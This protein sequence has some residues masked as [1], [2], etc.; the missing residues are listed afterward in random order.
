MS[1]HIIENL[2]SKAGNMA[3]NSFLYDWSL[4]EDTPDRLAV[5]LV[6]PRSGSRQNARDLLNAIGVE[7]HKDPLWYSQWWNPEEA[8]DIWLSHMHGFSWLRDLR[9]LGSALAREQGRLMIENWID[10]NGSWNADTWRADL[11]GRRLAMWICHYEFFCANTDEEFEDKLLFSI[12]KQAKHLSNTINKLS[13]IELL[14]AIKGLLYCAI[15]LDNHDEWLE[16]ALNA[17]EKETN[18]QI[19]PDGGHASRSPAILLDALEIMVDTRTALKTGGYPVPEFLTDVIN[20]MSAALR[21]LRYND[22]KLALFHG[23][24]EGDGDNINYVLAQTGTPAKL[25]NSLKYTGYERLEIGRTSLVM[26]TGKAISAVY[27]KTAHASALAF[28]FCYGK[29][30]LFVSCGSHPSSNQWKEALRFSAAHNTLCLDYR[31][32]CEIKK[33]GHFERKITRTTLHREE[34]EGA[35]LIIASHDG[36]V[37]LNGITHTRKLYLADEGNDLRGED[38]LN[39]AFELITPVEIAIRFHLHPSVS[40]SLIND[41]E[42]ILLRMPGGIG[43]RFT[44]SAGIIALEDSLYLGNGITPRKTKQIV[45]YGQMSEDEACIKWALKREQ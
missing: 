29:E 34:T 4:R 39:C 7:Q 9:A 5:K 11:I 28:E 27:D 32:S 16:Q 44:R 43:W 35:A 41:E 15:A 26:D 8:D 40:A 20:N 33:D 30:R 31:N 1:F 24:Q 37:P 42:E 23:A 21:L 19:L 10:C 13:N 18:I 38:Q 17:L 3:Y 36:Y 45:I 2:K 22:R 12:V 25:C 6:D 14:E